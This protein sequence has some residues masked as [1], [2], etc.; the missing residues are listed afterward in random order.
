MLTPDLSKENVA[1][2]KRD[3]AFDTCLAVMHIDDAIENGE[4]LFTESPRNL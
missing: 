2:A 3:D 4:D 1:N